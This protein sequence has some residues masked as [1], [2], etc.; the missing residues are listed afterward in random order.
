MVTRLVLVVEVQG[1]Q[2][3]LV[4]QVEH[5][6]MLVVPTLELHKVILQHLAA[7]AVALVLR[8]EMELQVQQVVLAVLEHTQQLQAFPLY[9]LAVGVVAHLQVQQQV[10]VVSGVVEM[11]P[12]AVV[13]ALVVLQTQAVAE[14]EQVTLQTQLPLAAQVQ[15]EL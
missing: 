5:M 13:L 14:A 7:E 3:L 15:V 9:M 2:L 10:S 6:E 8:V 4:D 11:V 12:L 1:R